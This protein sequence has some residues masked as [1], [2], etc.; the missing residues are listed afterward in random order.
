[1]N[2]A[3]MNSLAVC[4]VRGLQHDI[5]KIAGQISLWTCLISHPYPQSRVGL[6]LYCRITAESKQTEEVSKWSVQFSGQHTAQPRR[7]FELFRLATVVVSV[8]C[9]RTL[10][11]LM[12]ALSFRR[13]WAIFKQHT[14]L[15]TSLSGHEWEMVCPSYL[16]WSFLTN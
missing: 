8:S 15:M 5:Q 1:M 10:H 4:C 13:F 11:S 12:F 9:R 16:I 14:A 7:P 6:D 2:L 3:S